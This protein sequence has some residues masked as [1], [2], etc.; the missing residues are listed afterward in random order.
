MLLIFIN[1]IIIFSIRNFLLEGAYEFLI[2]FDIFGPKDFLGDFSLSCFDSELVTF[3]IA[4]LKLPNELNRWTEEFKSIIISE[5]NGLG[6]KVNIICVK[7]S[8]GIYMAFWIKKFL[9][10]LH[11]LLKLL[12]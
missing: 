12:K 6:D 8:T 10:H 4:L 7:N 3:D 2:V 1:I 9:I 5:F 11:N